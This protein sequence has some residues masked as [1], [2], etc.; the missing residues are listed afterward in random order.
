MMPALTEIETERQKWEK[1]YV[2]QE[3]PRMLYKVRLESGKPIADVWVIVNSDDERA[4]RER[5]GYAVTSQVALDK[6]EALQQ[7]I[8]EAAANSQHSVNRMT[9]TAQAE[10]AEADEAADTHLTG[11]E[12]LGKRGPGRPRKDA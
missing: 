10:Y 1:P 8:A 5:E 12:T 4:K 6:H 11:G 9:K 2:Y 7:E 3:Y